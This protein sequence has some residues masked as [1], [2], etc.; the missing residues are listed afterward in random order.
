MHRTIL[1]FL[2]T[3]TSYLKA[4]QGI[5]QQ[6]AQLPSHYL[7]IGKFSQSPL[8][9]ALKKIFQDYGKYH[10]IYHGKDKISSERPMFSATEKTSGPSPGNREV[11]FSLPLYPSFR[12]RRTEAS[13]TSAVPE[14][15]VP[16]PHLAPPPSRQDR[17][18]EPATKQ[19][20]G[21]ATEE[22]PQNRAFVAAPFPQILVRT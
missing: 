4:I 22:V 3:E 13:Y 17:N 18:R 16:Y 19:Y 10:G 21:K 14:N 5:T 12:R 20:D 6:I 8:Y 7:K 1:L 9:K 2:Y 11:S 15:A